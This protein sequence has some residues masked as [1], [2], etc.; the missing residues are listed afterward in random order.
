MI[1]ATMSSMSGVSSCWVSAETSRESEM[2][3]GYPARGRDRY[4]VPVRSPRER[5]PARRAGPSVRFGSPG[6]TGAAAER[7]AAAPS[8]FASALARRVADTGASDTSRTSEVVATARPMSGLA[9]SFE[10]EGADVD[11]TRRRDRVGIPSRADGLRRSADRDVGS[12]VT[13]A[14]PTLV[15]PARTG[16]GRRSRATAS[17]VVAE[18]GAVGVTCG[19]G[20]CG[21]ER[22]TAASVGGIPPVSVTRG[23]FA[24]LRRSPAARAAPAAKASRVAGGIIRPP[25][26][27]DRMLRRDRRSPAARR[28]PSDPRG[29]LRHRRPELWGAH[30]RRSRGRPLG[31]CI[32]V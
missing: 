32:G 27:S 24:R 4:A 29:S 3:T 11:S 17:T 30:G 19:T 18:A 9:P 25:V 28:R 23:V 31:C 7:V 21:R 15:K 12:C 2:S 8:P 20:R 5:V 16:R 13:V 26:G 14:S 10:P 1:A 22:A 6:R